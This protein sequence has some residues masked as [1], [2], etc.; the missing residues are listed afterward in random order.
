MNFHSAPSF[1]IFVYATFISNQS[2][3]TSRSKYIVSR[4]ICTFKIKHC[5]I[6]VSP[7]NTKMIY[8][9]KLALIKV[10]FKHGELLAKIRK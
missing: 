2:T 6:E 4:F 5:I 7:L 10:N 3:D 9:N 8:Y 1:Y